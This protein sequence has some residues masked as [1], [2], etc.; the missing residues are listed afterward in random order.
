MGVEQDEPSVSAQTQKR[1]PM[2]A[3]DL[4]DSSNSLGKT[5]L[6]FQLG[7][8]APPAEGSFLR[9]EQQANVGGCDDA[10]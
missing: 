2:F 9:S 6:G 10:R 1:S 3:G 5:Q 8:C 4:Q 7:K